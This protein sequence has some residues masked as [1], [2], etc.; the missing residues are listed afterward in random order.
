ITA[1][2]SDPAGGTLTYSLT[3]SAGGRFAIDSASGVV[4]VA[5]SSLIDYESAAGHSYSITVQASDGSLTSTQSFNIAVSN[6]APSTP[7]DSDPAANSVVEGATAGIYVGLTASATDPGGSSVTYS[8]TSDTSGGGFQID[9]V[10]GRVT[11]ADGSKISHNANPSHTYQITVEATDGGG[12]TASQTFTIN[13]IED[14]IAGAGVPAVGFEF[15]PLTD[16]AVATFSHA[17]GT[18]PV[19]DFTAIINWGDG[20]TS[21]GAVTLSGTTYTVL[22]SHT[23]TDE[24]TFTIRVQ[25]TE[26]TAS[27]T[28][29]TTATMKEELLP[30]GTEGTPDQRF[31]SEVYRD[32][33]DRKV[34][35]TGLA[36]W[37]ARLT[38]GETRTQVVGEIERTLEFEQHAVQELY[39]RYLHRDADP[40]GLSYFTQL[41][42]R[43]A[44]IEQLSALLAGSDEFFTSQGGGANDGFLNAVYEDALGR[45]IDATGLAWWSAQLASGQ[46]RTQVVDQILS[47]DEYHQDVVKA[48]YGQLLDRS[49]DAAGTSYW[50]SALKAGATDQQLWAAIAGSE[51]FYAK[52]K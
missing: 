42:A 4:T 7:S 23:Y 50:A 21:A 15:S 6:V 40:N 8:L 49:A 51:E 39:N 33:L 24:G 32:L 9:P 14:V 1:S 3:D 38:A 31:L 52:T 30:D 22:G 48:A 41:L 46:T 28:L 47:A 10:T 26:D 17:N 37:D 36:H 25:V 16:V 12:L 44:T 5:N 35:A 2:A 13:V 43:G 45:Q 34:D 27:A 19:G 11:V 20:A 29:T 18:Q